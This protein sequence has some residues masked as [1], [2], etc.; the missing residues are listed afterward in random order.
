MHQIAMAA[1]WAAFSL[2]GGHAPAPAPD[3]V[4]AVV[5]VAADEQVDVSP[6][7]RLDVTG[8]TVSDCEDMGGEPISQTL[9]GPVTCEGV[10]Y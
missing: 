4:P 6:P 3:P 10:D 8:V 9:H 1:V 5:V 7:T 2:A